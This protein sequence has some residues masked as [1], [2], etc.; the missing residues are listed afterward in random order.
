MG[1][2]QTLLKVLR[3]ATYSWKGKSPYTSPGGNST[4]ATSLAF[5]LVFLVSMWL[6]TS[7]SKSPA[8]GLRIADDAVYTAVV[9]EER[10]EVAAENA[11][12]RQA[13]QYEGEKAEEAREQAKVAAELQ[14]VEER[15]KELGGTSAA[16]G[17]ADVERKAS[18][19]EGP[20]DDSKAESLLPSQAAESKVE[21][22][23][24]ETETEES[25]SADDSD[26]KGETPE[27][28]AGSKVEKEEARESDKD[29]KDEKEE[30]EE[31]A[32]ASRPTSVAPY[33][34]CVEQSDDHIP[35]LDNEKALRQLKSTNHYEHRERHCPA[36]AEVP[37]CVLPL[38]DGYKPHITWPE[39]RDQIW[40]SNVPKPSLANYKADQNWVKADG[41]KFL[42]PGG[43]T[44]FKYGATRYIEWVHDVCPEL[45]WGKHVRVVLDMG[46]GVASFGAYLDAFDVRV[47]S[48]APKDEHDAQIQFALERGVSAL[49]GV[50]GTQRQPYP[51]NS[52]DAVHC[53][54]CR[55]PWHIEGGK[56]LL[57]LNR[58]IRPGGYF[59]WS[60]T[61]LC[62][63][64][65]AKEPDDK[66]IWSAMR[67]LTKNMCWKRLA[68]KVH[69]EFGIGVAVWQKP[70][71][72][73]C[74]EARPRK[75]IPPMCPE[76]N[77]ADAAWYEPMEAC[78][79]RVP[80]IPGA[81]AWPAEGRNRLVTAPA[82]MAGVVRG[83]FGKAGPADFDA[84]TE[85]WDREAKR[86]SRHLNMDWT[87]VRNVMDMDAHYG[88]F[89]AGISDKPLWSMNVVPA[90]NTSEAD[91]AMDTLPI[92]FERGLLGAYHDWCEAFNTYPRTYDLL[93]SDRLLGK[94]MDGNRCD[95]ELV[96]LEMDRIVRPMGYLIIRD[97]APHLPRIE[98]IA[99]QL[100]WEVKKVFRRPSSSVISFQKT[101][102]RP[103]AA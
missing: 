41:D 98:A 35:C 42:F 91:A 83:L 31:E 60:A 28:G 51:A 30:K 15:I 80:A 19:K 64:C 94:I 62:L 93:H 16:D 56:L 52:F 102:W 9:V 36:V 100:H 7:P 67:K 81:V 20:A 39:S 78:L 49:V 58:L 23:H 59:I 57:E 66:E 40:Y 61:P 68:K 34:L 13:A 71:D 38:P 50:M 14:Q 10:R 53:A 99:K 95:V 89:G 32:P 2:Q 48:V 29:E 84:D 79:H 1:L 22:A 44:Q 82:R 45:A 3:G 63:H 96:M 26:V 88:G 27:A 17:D 54:R 76:D 97:T 47:M 5:V 6:F 25:S 21:Q 101:M 65:S 73:A 18:R 8:S 12:E 4:L 87:T 75:T 90:R 74:Y 46:C 77:Q 33:P 69:R 24:T 92:V 72:N 70:T 11:R 55:V 103:A 37:R 43:G 86:Y 85:F